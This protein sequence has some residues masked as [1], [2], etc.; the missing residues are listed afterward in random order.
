MPELQPPC[1]IS[2]RLPATM[3]HFEYSKVLQPPYI[4]LSIPKSSSHHASLQ[5][6]RDLSEGFLP[7]VAYVFSILHPHHQAHVFSIT[8]GWN[9]Y[10]TTHGKYQVLTMASGWMTC[11]PRL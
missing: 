7:P 5:G 11:K 9:P 8:R 6:Q 1:I 10:R 4:T 3:H 2:H